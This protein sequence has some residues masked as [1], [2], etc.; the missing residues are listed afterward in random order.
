[1][2]LELYP[3]RVHFDNGSGGV[4]KVGR[5]ERRMV[6]APQVPGLPVFEAIDYARGTYP[7]EIQPLREG[8]REMFRNEIIRLEEWLGRVEKGLA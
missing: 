6:I 3:V 7:P 8:R 5:V 1:M 4:V 2:S